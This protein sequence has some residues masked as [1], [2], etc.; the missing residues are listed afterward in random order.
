MFHAFKLF[1]VLDTHDPIKIM[2]QNITCSLIGKMVGKVRYPWVCI[3]VVIFQSN[4]S[5][6]QA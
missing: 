1:L 6:L 5:Q 4:F 2:P 3:T